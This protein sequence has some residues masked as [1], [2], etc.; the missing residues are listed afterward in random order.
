[1]F[2][3]PFH[4]AFGLDINDQSIKIVQL[5]NESHSSKTPTYRYI[6]HKETRLPAGLIVNGEIIEPETVRKYLMHLLKGDGSKKDAIH[7][8]WV[9]VSV[10]S[11][12][13]FLRHIQLPK[14]AHDVIEEDVLI[15]AKK[16]IPFSA[17]EYYIDWQVVS[18]SQYGDVTDILIGAIPK[19]IANIYTYLVES[20]GLGVI[21]LEIEDLAISRA[22]ITH[23]K[24]YQHEARAVLDLGASRSTLIIYDHDIIQFSIGLHFNGQLV[25]DTIATK[26][27]ISLPEA[28]K[29]KIS[30]GSDY[31]KGKGIQFTVTKK[32]IDSLTIEIQR[33][34]AFYTSHF[35]EPNTV[36]H[37]TLCGGTSQLHGLSELLS[38]KLGIEATMGNVWKNLHTPKGLPTAH[39]KQLGLAT[40]IGL[41]LR[42]ADNPSLKRDIV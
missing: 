41:A 35:P 32:L 26:L 37:I 17:D 39:T 1:M 16:H 13:S 15:S 10:P 8:S 30:V 14:P 28:E 5:R 6:T 27:N 33:A 23:G 42:A 18:N 38:K 19:T 4:N 9:V 29:K 12:Q 40:A 24:V 7:G 3:N 21:A 20:V 36:T 34:I 25:T 2:A 11:T 22:M 31:K